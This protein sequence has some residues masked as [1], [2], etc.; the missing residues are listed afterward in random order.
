M[1]KL[2]DVAIRARIRAGERFEGRTDGDGLVD[3]AA[4]SHD[5]ALAAAL[6]FCRQVA[7]EGPGSHIDL[8]LA[9]ARQ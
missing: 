6:P 4:R 1:G 8:P 5:T 9:A 2:T 3:L 7:R